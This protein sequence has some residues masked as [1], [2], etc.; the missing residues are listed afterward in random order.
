MDRKKKTPFWTTLE[1]RVYKGYSDVI[2]VPMMMLL[3]PPSTEEDTRPITHW[4]QA[5]MFANLLV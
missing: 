1:Y 3:E 5:Y 4:L 2:I